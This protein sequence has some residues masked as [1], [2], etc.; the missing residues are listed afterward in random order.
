METFITSTK[1][2]M[3]IRRHVNNLMCKIYQRYVMC[4]TN[5]DVSLMTFYA[6]KCKGAIFNGKE[7]YH[8]FG[9]F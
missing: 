2:V 7:K 9:P 5:D 4:T 1:S 6:C 8:M 3:G